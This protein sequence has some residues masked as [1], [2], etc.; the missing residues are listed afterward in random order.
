LSD[1]E[2]VIAAVECLWSLWCSICI[3]SDYQW[4]WKLFQ[5]GEWPSQRLDSQV[6]CRIFDFLV[7]KWH[8]FWW[9]FLQLQHFI[10]PKLAEFPPV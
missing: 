1:H 7:L 5:S 4:Q 2:F 9:K 8:G 10:H 6:W 3:I